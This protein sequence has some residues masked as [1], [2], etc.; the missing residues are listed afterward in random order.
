M[1]PV[2]QHFWSEV[3][4][5]PE[6]KCVTLQSNMSIMWQMNNCNTRNIFICRN[7]EK[8]LNITIVKGK[9]YLVHK[10]SLT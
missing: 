3:S 2:M 8:G 6:K 1:K 7:R 9:N 5:S 10:F 4:P